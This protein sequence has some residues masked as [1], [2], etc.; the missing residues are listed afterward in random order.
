[1]NSSHI[2]ALRYLRAGAEKSFGLPSR[3]RRVKR[4]RLKRSGQSGELY[5]VQ[6]L[7]PQGGVD[8][9]PRQK[10]FAAEIFQALAQ[11]FAAL[12]KGGGGD[13]FQRRKFGRRHR[14]GQRLPRSEER[15]V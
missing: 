5:N 3:G 12:A 8:P 7:G 13:L 11:H 9:R 14:L 15:R 4:K 1:M 6:L 10:A 2:D